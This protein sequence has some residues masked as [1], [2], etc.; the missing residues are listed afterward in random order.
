[1][2]F[3]RQF[4]LFGFVGSL[5]F[6]VDSGVLYLLKD[7]V[8]LYIGR[9]FSFI[10]AVFVT[11]ILNRNMTFADRTSGKSLGGEFAR[12]FLLMLI[13][14]VVNYGTYVAVISRVATAHDQ[15][16][17]AV[18]AGSIAGLGVNL[19]SSKFMLYRHRR[20]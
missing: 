8:G 16:I 9:I 4:L 1:M 15:P 18:A 6:V 12:Y 11:W 13:G 17:W 19:L 7:L 14:G 20:S 2:K 10:S 5:G 3:Q